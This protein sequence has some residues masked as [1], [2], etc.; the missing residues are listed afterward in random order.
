MADTATLTAPAKVLGPLAGRAGEIL[1]PEAL[2][3]LAE[4]HRRF[5]SRRLELLAAR[6]ERQKR[7]DAGEKPDFLPATR[8]IREGE[9]RVAPLPPDLLDRRVEI[10]GP[11]ER[12]MV[13][14]ALNSGA[15][16]FM[17]DFEDAN[18]PTWDNNLEGHAN[19]IDAIEGVIEFKNPDGKEYRLD[20]K[21]A[22]L[23]VRPRGWH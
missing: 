14:N 20:E 23:L 16:I 9:W 7:L 2:A 17:A 19:L 10:T 12:K 15:R 11:V 21:T 8:H 4:L 6:A 1:T 3:F 13:I 18:S 5:D 22:Y